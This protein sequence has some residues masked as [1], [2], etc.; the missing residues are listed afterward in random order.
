MAKIPAKAAQ[1]DIV[2]EQAAG[3]DFTL[4]WLDEEGSP[5]PLTSYTALLEAK[6][7]TGTVILSWTDGNEITLGGTAGTIRVEV[8]DSITAAYTFDELTHCLKLTSP[9]SFVTRLIKGSLTLDA[10]C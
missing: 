6:D 3:L 4:T 8:D 5:V 9:T 1:L 7:A 10:E 2:I